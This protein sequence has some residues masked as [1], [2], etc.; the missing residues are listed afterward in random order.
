MGAAR[1]PGAPD[2]RIA[3]WIAPLLVL[4]LWELAARVGWLP[5]LLLPAPSAVFV[6]AATLAQ[7]GELWQ[8]ARISI[9]R[10]LSGLLLGGAAGLVLGVLNGMVRQAAARADDILRALAAVPVLA[11]APLILLWVGAEEIARLALLSLAAFFPVYLHTVRG[12]RAVDPAL[13]ETG[14]SCG[15]RGWPLYRDVILPGALPSVLAGLRQAL[16]LAWLVLAALELLAAPSGIGRLA[17][18]A[19]EPPRADALLLGIALYAALS[20]ASD[21]LTAALERRLLRWSP[22]H[23]PELLSGIH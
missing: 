6:A 9:E 18:P 19:G 20:K 4:A 5:S 12:I 1:H 14:R 3:R 7:S 2:A 17:L 8:Y 22:A 15:L 10:A 11:F 21:A 16:G 23:R 13:I